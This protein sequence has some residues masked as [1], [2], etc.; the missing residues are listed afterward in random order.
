[1]EWLSDPQAWIALLTL[2]FLEIVL[3]IDN[4]VFVSILTGKLPKEQQSKA[5]RIGLALAMGMR[6][7]LLFTISWIMQLTK[8]L[9][10]FL[11]HEFTGQGL[12]LLLGGMFLMW[13][14]VSEIHHKLEGEDEAGTGG[15][16][17]VT[18]GSAILQITMLDLVFSLDSVI[19]AVGMAS[20]YFAVMVIAVLISVGVMIAFVN[21]ICSFVE[22]HPTVKML[23]LSFLLLIG[24]T[25][26]GEGWGMHIP[27]GYVYFAMGF[28]VFVEFLNLKLK[29]AG[30]PIDLHGPERPAM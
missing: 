28:S 5:R 30:K 4:L 8:P 21:P 24:F 19:S 1:M 13:K 10:G 6:I 3:G 7:A 14:S 9:F 2:T 22:R 16:K 29:K 25:L 27:K 23:A 20:Q 26:I 17:A 18:F 12:I 11:G 15:S